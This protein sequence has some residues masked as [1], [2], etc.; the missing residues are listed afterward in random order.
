MQ[1]DKS[2]LEHMMDAF[3]TRAKK[4]VKKVERTMVGRPPKKTKSSAGR[5]AV[6][7]NK[8]AKKAAKGTTKRGR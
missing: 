8:R 3:E 2:L 5:K 4:T 1:A 6:G 7:K